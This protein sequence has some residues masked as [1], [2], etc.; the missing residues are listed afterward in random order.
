MALSEEKSMKSTILSA[1]KSGDNQVSG[2]EI[3]F[4]TKQLNMRL[5]EALNKSKDGTIFP[6]EANVVKKQI[7]QFI[8]AVNR[9]KADRVAS[10]SDQPIT[11][12][13]IESS[14]NLELD[15]KTLD[16]N[17][18]DLAAITLR[19]IAPDLPP[20]QKVRAGFESLIRAKLIKLLDIDQ[21]GKVTNDEY[22]KHSGDD[23]KVELSPQEVRSTIS[24]ALGISK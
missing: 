3:F 10:S 20:N 8:C 23:F 16:D 11:I 19:T 12:E 4:K 22:F 9:V 6:A 15:P 17:V 18:L 13:E 21:D 2:P 1:D 24:K 14:A 5:A 7:E